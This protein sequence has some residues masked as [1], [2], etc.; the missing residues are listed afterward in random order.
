MMKLLG[1]LYTAECPIILQ[2]GKVVRNVVA[3]ITTR[4]SKSNSNYIS[5]LYKY[6]VEYFLGMFVKIVHIKTHYSTADVHVIYDFI[7]LG[8]R[9]HLSLRKIIKHLNHCSLQSLIITQ[10]LPL[11]FQTIFSQIT[12]SFMEIS[13]S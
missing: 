7:Q 13:Q 1:S 12:L 9:N 6:C 11:H 2:H 3:C 5:R 8:L 10:P 4:L